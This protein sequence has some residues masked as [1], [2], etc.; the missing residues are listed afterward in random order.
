M[1]FS[2]L[3]P[4]VSPAHA[5][6]PFTVTVVYN[7]GSG[8]VSPVPGAIVTVSTRNYVMP[9]DGSGFTVF[10]YTANSSGVATVEP[11]VG[12]GALEVR[13]SA[14]APG[15]A[16]GGVPTTTA[17][18]GQSLSIE[19]A[20]YMPIDAV[21]PVTIVLHPIT[22]VTGAVASTDAAA[23]GVGASV[24]LW[25]RATPSDV[26][27]PVTEVRTDSAG[28]FAASSVPAGDYRFEVR[29]A[30]T[31]RLVQRLFHPLTPV[32]DEAE[33]VT[34][35]PQA[36]RDVG[37]LTVT[38]WSLETGRIEGIDRYETAVKIS[39]QIFDGAVPAPVIYLVNGLA[40]PDALSATPLASMAGGGLLLTAPTLVPATVVDEL[41]RLKPERV[42][43]VGGTAVVS[44][45]VENQV[46]T[47]AQQW[48]GD[49]DRVAGVDRYDTSRELIIDARD[50]LSVDLAQ[51]AV[52]IATGLDFPDA[53]SAASAAGAAGLPLVLVGGAN[54]R[55]LPAAT[56]ALID[57]LA[58]SRLF[59]A[60]GWATV[61]PLAINEFAG[62]RG[63]RVVR[64]GGVDR[65]ETSRLINDFFFGESAVTLVANGTQFP[66]ALSAGPLS[67]ALGV[68]LALTPPTCV[69]AQLARSLAR[70]GTELA[71]LIGGPG[72]LSSTVAAMSS[73]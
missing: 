10:P 30:S 11:A 58:P 23:V 29:S 57:S 13:V 36:T 32:L 26:W 71:V 34:A 7:D 9:E 47:L 66:D 64:F 15:G 59:I 14:R 3:V 41:R 17:F 60:G 68:P 70:Q 39:E 48:S 54:E 67:A 28:R 62:L 18:W 63:L 5:T 65:Y 24:V 33:I 31:G 73:C 35:A 12:T 25:H 72:A 44:T 49:V 37:T 56:A 69:H 8:V 2:H 45:A 1:W 22:T 4:P 42:V 19:T 20:D 46:R 6:T 38:P 27:R 16:I 21:Q 50:E 43:I 51:R 40:F 55:A 53:L 52:F 61:S